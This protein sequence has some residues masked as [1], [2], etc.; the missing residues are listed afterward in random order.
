LH[1]FFHNMEKSAL[2][3]ERRPGGFP[4]RFGGEIKA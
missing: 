2:Q 3:P 1:L 4:E